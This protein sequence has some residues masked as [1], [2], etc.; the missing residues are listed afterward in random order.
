MN[1]DASAQG[2]ILALG[3]TP[4]DP[5]LPGEPIVSRALTQIQA[6]RAH[7]RYRALVDKRRAGELDA[8]GFDTALD[9]LMDELS[10]QEN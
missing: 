2:V 8:H 1:A 10:E 3:A 9:A 6:V 7:P 4:V 5:T